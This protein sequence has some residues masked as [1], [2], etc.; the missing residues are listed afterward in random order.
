MKFT[1][2]YEEGKLIGFTML[3]ENDADYWFFEQKVILKEHCGEPD[4][5]LRLLGLDK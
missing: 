5:K 1:P 4:C 2:K 3:P